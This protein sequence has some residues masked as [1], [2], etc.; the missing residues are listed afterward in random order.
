MVFC[1]N[2]CADKKGCYRNGKLRMPGG[3]RGTKVAKKKAEEE[4]QR[5][6][7]WRAKKGLEGD[8]PPKKQGR[9]GGY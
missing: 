3:N 2:V 8:L 1:S 6:N 4:R 5:R 9:R 7:R